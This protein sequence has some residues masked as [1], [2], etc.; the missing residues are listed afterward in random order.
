MK[1]LIALLL[2][3]G[4]TDLWPPLV[5]RL[6]L[7]AVFIPAGLGKFIEHDVYIERFDR[8]G[9]AAPGTVAYL[10]GIVEVG[11]GLLMLT[12]VAPRLV[13]IGLIGNMVGAIATAGRVDG[14]RDIYVPLIMIAVLLIVVRLGA[15]RFSLHERVLGRFS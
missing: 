2:H 5:A 12:G 3:P 13:G 14:G 9:F 6:V 10:V 8:W 1:R 4:R 11:G 7:A 15:G